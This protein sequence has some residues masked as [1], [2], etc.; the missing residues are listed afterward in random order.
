MSGLRQLTA[1][2]E[3][4]LSER[5]HKR[6]VTALAQTWILYHLGSAVAQRSLL[7][8]HNKC[9]LYT[10]KLFMKIVD[11][12]RHYVLPVC[13]SCYSH[14]EE[15]I[16]ANPISKVTDYERWVFDLHND[17]NE[18]IGKSS[19]ADFEAVRDY[20]RQQLDT[21][22]PKITMTRLSNALP[23]IAGRYCYNC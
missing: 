19:V 10:F 3:L 1:A 18:R 4:R 17:V 16:T 9:K 11:D 22:G 12:I 15:Y 7:R 8:N 2:H 13:A 20:Y 23:A 5:D 21:L 6:R 14:H